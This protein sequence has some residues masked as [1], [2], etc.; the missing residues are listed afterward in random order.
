MLICGMDKGLVAKASIAV[1]AS[2]AKV[3]D[4]LINPEVIR[5][6]M[7][8]TDV[9]PDWKIGSSIVWKGKW[10]EKNTRIKE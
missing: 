10:E 1:E 5:Q 4:A 8:G 6:Y 9:V 7:F 2:I 3:W